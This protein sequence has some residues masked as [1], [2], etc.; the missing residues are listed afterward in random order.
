M[1]ALFP[2]DTAVL[3]CVALCSCLGAP[4]LLLQPCFIERCGRYIAGRIDHRRGPCRW[5]WCRTLEDGRNDGDRLGADGTDRGRRERRDVLT[6]VAGVLGLPLLVGGTLCN[7]VVVLV[8]R[9]N[10]Q[11]RVG[12]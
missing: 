1:A 8:T 12:G 10:R 5:R 2:L 7:I 4:S 9:N 3:G 11:R 6:A